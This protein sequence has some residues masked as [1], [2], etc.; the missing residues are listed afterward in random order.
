MREPQ[1][2]ERKYRNKGSTETREAQK[3]RRKH[4]ETQRDG[5]E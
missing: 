3:E 4:R 2:Q 5:M 1:G